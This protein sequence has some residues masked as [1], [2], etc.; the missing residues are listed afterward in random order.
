MQ[1]R[2]TVICPTMP[3]HRDEKVDKRYIKTREEAA[4]EAKYLDSPPAICCGPHM[5]A[6]VLADGTVGPSVD[7][8]T[9]TTKPLELWVVLN[10]HGEVVS[11]WMAGPCKEVATWDSAE[12]AT[13]FAAERRALD[14]NNG[15]Y[16]VVHLREIE[17]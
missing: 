1:N 17:S 16:R 15:P 9:P 12:D 7:P 8:V 5:I 13:E 3:Y 4:A 11:T 6:P 2:W 10:R 14:P